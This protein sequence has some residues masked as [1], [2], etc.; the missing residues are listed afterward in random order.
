MHTL[1]QGDEVSLNGFLES[2]DSRRLE[3]EIRLEVLGNFPD[4]TLEWELADQEFGRFLV[5]TDFTESD[6]TGA[7][8]MGLLDTS[9][10]L[11]IIRQYFVFHGGKG[12]HTGADLRAALEASCLRG[13]FPPVDLRGSLLHTVSTG[14][15]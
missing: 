1:E 3:S 10:G 5:A 6:G 7:V 14:I 8:T 9:R 15:I 13:A 11:H 2:T 4:E 12:E